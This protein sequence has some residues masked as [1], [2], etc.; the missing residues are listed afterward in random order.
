ME[1]GKVSLTEVEV[2]ELRVKEPTHHNFVSKEG[3]KFGQ[4]TTLFY[5]GRNA[6]GVVMYLCKCDC[7]NFT[8]VHGSDIAPNR[9]VTSCGCYRQ[10]VKKEINAEVKQARIDKAKESK[11]SLVDCLTGGFDHPWIFNCDKHGDFVSSYYLVVYRETLCPSCAV[12]GYKSNQPGYFY[13]NAVFDKDEIVAVKYGITNLG[14]D[15]RLKQIQA[16]SKFSL[17]NILSLYFE[18]GLEAR[19]L[20]NKFSKEFGKKVLK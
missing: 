18:N 11:Y 6:R 5:V 3:V 2:L 16:K 14:V 19:N 20:E 15:V 4:L 1:C 7:G 17:D 8:V 13:L 10:Q 9:K 12:T